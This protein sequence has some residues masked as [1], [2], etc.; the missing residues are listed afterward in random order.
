MI[1]AIILDFDGVVIESVDLKTKAFREMF[2]GQP[3]CEQ[4]IEY[5]LK[6]NGKSRFNKFEWLYKNI[7]NKPLSE[8]EKKTLGDRFSGIILKKN[9]ECPYV[10][11][12]IEF[13]REFHGKLPIY[14]ASITPQ[15][16]LQEIIDKRNLNQYFKGVIGTMGS[17]SDIINKIIAVEKISPDEIVFVGDTME[18]YVAAQETKVSFVARIKQETF[19]ELPILKFKNLKEVSDWLRSILG[20]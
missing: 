9:I 11:G 2:K 20:F 8:V 5:H 13:L 18:D 17:K 7:L 14:I 6:N 10:K 1:K 15:E 3:Y 4:F 16:E 12:A 19:G